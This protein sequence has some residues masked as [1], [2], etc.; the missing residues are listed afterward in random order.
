MGYASS[1]DFDLQKKSVTD[2][3]SDHGVLSVTKARVNGIDQDVTK[4]DSIGESY[5]DIWDCRLRNARTFAS[6]PQ[7]R[8]PSFEAVIT[9]HRLLAFRE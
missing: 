4:S 5:L 9:H 6:V 8:P 3:D 2:Y 7:D 1:P